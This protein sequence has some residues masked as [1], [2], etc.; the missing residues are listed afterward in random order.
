MISGTIHGG[1]PLIIASQ[2]LAAEGITKG[3]GKVQGKMHCMKEL[4]KSANKEILGKQNQRQFH[5]FLKWKEEDSFKDNEVI[6]VTGKK[7]DP[8]GPIESS[9]YT[10]SE[11]YKEMVKTFKPRPDIVTSSEPDFITG[12]RLKQVSGLSGHWGKELSNLGFKTMMKAIKD[13]DNKVKEKNNIEELKQ[14]LLCVIGTIDAANQKIKDN[15]FF[16]TEHGYIKL[17]EKGYLEATQNEDEATF[18]NEKKHGDK[19]Y[20]QVAGGEWAQYYL[21]SHWDNGSCVYSAWGDALYFS[22]DRA[23]L[24]ARSGKCDTYSLKYHEPNNTF[25]CYYL[26]EGVYDSCI[27]AKEKKEARSQKKQRQQRKQ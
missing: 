13:D 12:A 6:K 22:L 24:R 10:P 23:R 1:N 17:S 4:K 26:V 3:L 20:Y 25:Y 7:P 8:R 16:R 15:F 27:V 5:R 2:L 19:I 21:S 11:N 14:A 9:L 18:W